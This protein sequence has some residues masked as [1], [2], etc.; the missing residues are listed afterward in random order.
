[1]LN[2][3]LSQGGR[4]L[5]TI[6][7]GVASPVAVIVPIVGYLLLSRDIELRFRTQRRPGV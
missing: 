4:L 1:M 3:L 7:A 2:H 5:A 6:P